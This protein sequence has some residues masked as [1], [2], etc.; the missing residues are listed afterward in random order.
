MK[1]DTAWYIY[2]VAVA[3][4]YVSAVSCVIHT[5]LDRISCTYLARSMYAPA[6]HVHMYTDRT[7]ALYI[8]IRLY[9]IV[10]GVTHVFLKLKT[11]IEV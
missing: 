2:W 6:M 5:G 7:M 11:V 1:Y 10:C 8:Y 9:I 3:W 4:M